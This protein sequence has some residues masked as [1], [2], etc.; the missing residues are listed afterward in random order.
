MVRKDLL[1]A[2]LRS[3]RASA[4]DER[5]LD[6]AVPDDQIVDESAGDDLDRAV[7]GRRHEIWKE[8]PAITRGQLRGPRLGR[9]RQRLEHAG[10][11]LIRALVEADLPELGF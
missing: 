5:A 1:D 8:A 6:F 11:L 3:H 2:F 7:E 10:E 9:R 4:P